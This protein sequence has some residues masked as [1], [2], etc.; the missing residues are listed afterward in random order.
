MKALPGNF[1]CAL[2]AL[3]SANSPF[4]TLTRIGSRYPGNLSLRRRNFYDAY[5][6]LSR[7]S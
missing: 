5:V 1:R 4:L 2:L 6:C 3:Q 7:A